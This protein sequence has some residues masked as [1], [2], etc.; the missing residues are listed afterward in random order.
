MGA[1]ADA[2]GLDQCLMNLATNAQD[3]MPGGGTLTVRV[4]R[5]WLDAATATVHGVRPGEYAVIQV[6]DTGAG[7]DEA[8]R[9]RAF[10]P[11]FTTKPRGKGTGLGLAMVHGLIRQ[12]PDRK[13]THLKS[14]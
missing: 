9:Q 5:R 7:M 13:N 11:L 8:T 12:H 6:E 10:E 2:T 4:S 1:R 3:A 14:T